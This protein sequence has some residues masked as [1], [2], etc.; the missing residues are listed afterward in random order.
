MRIAFLDLD[1]TLLMADSNQLWMAYL[2]AQRWIGDAEVA[3][4]EQFIADYANGVLDFVRLQAFREG[5]DAS[6]PAERLHEC[7]LAFQREV[8]LPAIA[9]QAPDLLSELKTQRW[10]TVVVSATRS[11][12]VEP[13]ARYLG[14]D[15][16]IA[17]CFG[18]QKV[19]QVE[20]WLAVQGHRLS[21]LGES[22]FYSD[23]HNDLPLL[24]AVRNP[25]VVDPDPQLAQLA[26]QYDWPVMS[27]RGPALE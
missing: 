13:V 12:L 18:A 21:T 7:Q 27:L 25:M 23:S 6:L 19:H 26:R 1:H 14:V 2:H 22:R 3:E 24:K 4:H 9:P 11:S 16:V 20:A 10:V 5:I 8:L 17:P 15:H